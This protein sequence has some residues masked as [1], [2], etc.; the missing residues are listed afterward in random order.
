M[1][2][3]P[4]ILLVIGAIENVDDQS[5]ATVKNLT[6]K[7][8]VGTVGTPLFDFE[9]GADALVPLGAQGTMSAS[10]IELA[11]LDGDLPGLQSA[12]GPLIPLVMPSPATAE[13]APSVVQM[14][15]TNQLVCTSGKLSGSMLASFD[16]KT[17]TISKPLTITVAGLTMQ[18]HGVGSVAGQ[19]QNVVNNETVQITAAATAA[20]DMSAVHDL[21]VGVDTSFA[22]IRLS[23]GQILLAKSEDGKLVPVGPLDQLQSVNVEVDDADLARLDAVV[24]QL[25]N[26]AATPAPGE[27]VIVVVPPPVV[28]SGTA[29]LKME[30]SRSGNTTTANISQA[31]V[32]GLAIKSGGSSTAWPS[33]ITA[34][35]T[36]AV[37][38]RGCDG[39]RRR[40][41]R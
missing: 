41:C 17:M 5:V 22:K 25:F 40:I 1:A 20:G 24:N 21:N 9:I 18:E 15:A 10:R 19:D 14:L 29:T 3:V 16:G 2:H 7:A 23:N 32:H 11:K 38:T 26:Q 13:N 8:I 4:A 30:V 37:E 33:D 39:S 12:M 27:K 31:V 35:L 6:V 34:K 28:T 36:A